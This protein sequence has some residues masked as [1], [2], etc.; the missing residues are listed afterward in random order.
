[1]LTPVMG[2]VSSAFSIHTAMIVPLM[3]FAVVAWFAWAG[4]PRADGELP[5]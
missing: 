4:G 5:A 3:C 2:A 1:V